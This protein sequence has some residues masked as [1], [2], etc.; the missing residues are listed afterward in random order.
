MVGSNDSG[1]MPSG[2]QEG[3]ALEALPVPLLLIEPPAGLVFVNRAARALFG[4][5]P[6]DRLLSSYIRAPA[7]AEAL[8][9]VVAEGVPED[10]AFTS[11]RTREERELFAHLAQ[12]A[13]G[14]VVVLIEDRTEAKR[15]EKLRRDFVANASHELRT[16]L[17]AIAGFI[18][19]LQGPAADD[20]EARGRFLE[21]MAREAARMGRLIDD[22]MAL[23]RIEMTEHLLPEISVDLTTVLA[24]VVD[25]LTPLAEEHGVALRL[26]PA[27]GQ[28]AVRGDA[29]DLRRLF[30][31]LVENAIRH[32]GSGGLVEILPAQADPARPGMIGVTVRDFGPGI[33]RH[34]L[35]R[36]TERFYRIPM[37]GG[38]TPEGTGLGLS[39]VKHIL[40][41]HRG[42]LTVRSALGE[43]AA[44]TA[45][46]P[47]IRQTS[48]T[49]ADSADSFKK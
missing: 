33:A 48:A 43:G 29:D 37:S 16:P 23:G 24:E 10:V 25:L 39:I 28:G 8:S 9:R 32:G 17:A 41:R 27:A 47:A 38:A 30:V 34:H 12:T 26:D 35:P 13:A 3:A 49:A 36:L 46:M 18:E 6:D 20:P 5:P 22:L 21:I 14:Q 42:D 7:L 15:V 11:R 40:T 4:P 19:T 1:V 45:W 31:N 44:F 2:E